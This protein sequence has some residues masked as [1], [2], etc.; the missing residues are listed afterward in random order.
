MLSGDGIL[1]FTEKDQYKDKDDEL[2]MSQ[3]GS[4]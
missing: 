4:G 2:K 3:N 1:Y